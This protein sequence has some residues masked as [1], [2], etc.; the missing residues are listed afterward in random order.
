[1]SRNTAPRTL[2]RIAS[3]IDANGWV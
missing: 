2:H 1:M 3:G